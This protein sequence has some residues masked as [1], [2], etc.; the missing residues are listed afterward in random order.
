VEV[1]L[2]EPRTTDVVVRNSGWGFDMSVGVTTT[3]FARSF[4]GVSTKTLS[5]HLN[6]HPCYCS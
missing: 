4:L 2:E 1:I 3:G 5:G 6:Q